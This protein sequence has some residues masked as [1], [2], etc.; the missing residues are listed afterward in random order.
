MEFRGLLEEAKRRDVDELGFV[1]MVMYSGKDEVD[2][3]EART[4]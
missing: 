4:G 1:M 2:L 3:W